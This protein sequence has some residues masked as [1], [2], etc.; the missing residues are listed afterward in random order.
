[1]TVQLLCRNGKTIPPVSAEELATMA[2]CQPTI[3]PTTWGRTAYM[4]RQR[5]KLLSFRNRVLVPAE[6]QAASLTNMGRIAA[7]EH[8]R[9]YDL[10]LDRED[11]IDELFPV[12]NAMVMDLQE[13]FGIQVRRFIYAG[14]QKSCRACLTVLASIKQLQMA[15]QAYPQ[16]RLAQSSA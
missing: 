2:A 14:N 5:F 7:S 13:S 3:D 11:S 12:C 1:M 6:K 16:L 8:R 4:R 9:A 10:V 15:Q